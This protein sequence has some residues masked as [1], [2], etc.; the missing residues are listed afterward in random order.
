MGN[1][2]TLSHYCMSGHLVGQP[3][4]HNTVLLFKIMPNVPHMQGK[5]CLLGLVCSITC[6]L[7]RSL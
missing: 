5:F 1:K 2:P 7:Y 4:S 3:I 6:I